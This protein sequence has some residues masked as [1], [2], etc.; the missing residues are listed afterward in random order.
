V[1]AAWLLLLGWRERRGTQLP[2]ALGLPSMQ[3]AGNG[4]DASLLRWYQDRA[5]PAPE[6]AW[7]LSVPLLVYRLAMLAWALWLAQAVVR[8]L[9]W[10]WQCFTAGETWRPLRA[11][12]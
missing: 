4:S 10:G 6:G 5:A 7:L 11:A 1:V 3:I 2:E 9:R 8:W 12:G